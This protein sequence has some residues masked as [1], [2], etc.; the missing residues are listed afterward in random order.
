MKKIILNKRQV[1]EV[2]GADFSYLDK[3]DN[4]FNFYNSDNEIVTSSQI[5]NDSDG[6]PITTDGYASQLAPRY[7]YGHRDVR[8]TISCNKKNKKNSID[9]ENKDLKNK[10]FKIPDNLYSILKNLSVKYSSK[11][12]SKGYKR[13]NNL[14]KMR[15]LTTNEM[16]QLKNYFDKLSNSDEEYNIIGGDEM[17]EWVNKELNIATSI[18]Y[19]GKDIKRKMG[20]NN[21]FIKNHEKE[22]GNGKGHSGISQNMKKDVEFNYE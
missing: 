6:E 15:N 18:N 10:T 4:D 8:G 9:E 17:K 5:N 12:D 13:L 19:R 1:T 22:Y 20:D 7:F 11:K 21:A 3:D 14:I 16:Y 2:I